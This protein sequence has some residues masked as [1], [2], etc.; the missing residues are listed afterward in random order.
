M[1]VVARVLVEG[2]CAVPVLRNASA[3]LVHGGEAVATTG[4]SA[5]T[6]LLVEGD[7]AR[8]V[9]RSPRSAR[10]GPPGPPRT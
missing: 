2:Q 8:L 9:L 10:H 4:T 1:P 3:L 6:R 5:I 7:R